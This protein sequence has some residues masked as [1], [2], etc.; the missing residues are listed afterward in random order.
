MQTASEADAAQRCARGV[1]V[2]LHP[3]VRRPHARRNICCR[4][5][6]QSNGFPQ[7]DG[8]GNH[9]AG[10]LPAH[11]CGVEPTRSSDDEPRL[12]LGLGQLRPLK[13]PVGAGNRA[14][15]PKR[16]NVKP[17]ATHLHSLTRRPASGASRNS[18]PGPGHPQPA[19]H[20]CATAGVLH[21]VPSLAIHPMAECSE[22]AIATF[23]A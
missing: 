22:E 20:R 18:S 17:Q 16:Q 13:H 3:N 21:R 2:P 23:T 5:R 4:R 8:G 19:V 14:S 9:R 15:S 10:E 1:L 6:K 7:S 11:Q 12:R